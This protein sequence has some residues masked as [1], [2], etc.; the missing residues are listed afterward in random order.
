MGAAASRITEHEI[1]VKDPDEVQ[2]F[3][4]R[5]TILVMTDHSYQVGG[6]IQELTTSLE[7]SVELCVELR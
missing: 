3:K 4:R 7:P 1:I 5:A 6:N 2:E